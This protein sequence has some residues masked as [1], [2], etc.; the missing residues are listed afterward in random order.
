V[1]LA[2]PNLRAAVKDLLH[3]EHAEELGSG[4][5]TAAHRVFR[6]R[7]A[8]AIVLVS[9]LSAAAGWRA[10]VFEERA[11]DSGAVYYQ[12]LLL[13]QRLER[14]HEGRVAQDIT[15][16]GE[17]EQAWFLSHAMSSDPQ[18]SEQQKV[19][20]EQT[21]GDFQTGEVPATYTDGTSS[22]DP[23]RA[24]AREVASDNDLK[25]LH[26]TEVLQKSDS[27]RN[28][29]VNMTGVAALFVAALVLL[30][31]AQVTLGRRVRAAP[32]SSGG[33]KTGWSISHTFLTAGMLV[34]LVAGA[35][36]VLVMVQ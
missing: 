9:I 25:A 35:L 6:S 23:A 14:S 3:G 36:F 17:L 8:L 13:Q 1:S 15:Q 11:S 26:P 16:Y 28:Q 21:L 29:A 5:G 20:A 12:D 32:K 22:Y 4:V 33:E 7:V 18:S 34:A 19:A 31:L 10:S 2:R 27:F 30:T 24:Y